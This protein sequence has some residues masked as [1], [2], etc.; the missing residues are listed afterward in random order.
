MLKRSFFLLFSRPNGL[1]DHHR[2]M[3]KS[4]IKSYFS[5]VRSLYKFR[6]LQVPYGTKKGTFYALSRGV[7]LASYQ[8]ILDRFLIACIKMYCPLHSS[9]KFCRLQVSNGTK[10]GTF[11]AMP[12]EEK[13]GLVGHQN[14]LE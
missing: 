13:L 12:Q 9:Y 8:N 11:G 7:G 1:L 5:Y 3:I 14:F 4:L 2:E 10:S 6:R